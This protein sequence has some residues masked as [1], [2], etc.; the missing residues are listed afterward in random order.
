M[1]NFD[2]Y[3]GRYSRAALRREGGVLEITLH[4]GQGGSLVWDEPA[5]RELGDLFA[6]V[7]RDADNRVVILTGAGD[8]FCS[9]CDS[10]SFASVGGGRSWDKIFTEGRRLI[11]NLLGIDVPMIA[12]V[13]GPA[14]W[15]A[16]L[17]VLCDV[18]LAAEHA[19]FQDAPHLPNA[20]PADGVHT[21]WP[22]LLG[23]S[24]GRY[25]LLTKEIIDAHEAKRLGFVHEV[26]SKDGL[27]ERAWDLARQLD[28]ARPLVLKYTRL[29]VTS[30]IKAAVL[31][32]LAYGLALEGL[33]A[34]SD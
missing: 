17:A 26:L 34:L 24:R 16:E 8:D 22:A 4:N 29:S 19:V 10:A 15:H 1:T 11:E 9:T 14:T 21:V 32:D 6:D 23:P 27:L 18:V 7:G 20:V 12:A 25:F 5:H 3:S 30:A 28:A 13:N 33:A 31:P 2:D